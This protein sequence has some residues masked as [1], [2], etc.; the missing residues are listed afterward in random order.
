M[1]QI[2][3]HAKQ[4]ADIYKQEGEDKANKAYQAIIEDNKLKLWEISALK[5]EVFKLIK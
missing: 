5:N 1:A 4:I 2:H 3:I